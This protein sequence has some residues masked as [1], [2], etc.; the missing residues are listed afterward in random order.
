[1]NPVI[2]FLSD[3][4]FRTILLG[5][6]VLGSVSGILGT[7]AVLRRQGLVGDA[8]AH[9]ALPGVAGAF[10]LTG[11][12]S[13][14]VLMLGAAISGAIGLLI[15]HFV[16]RMSKTG[17]GTMLGVVLTSMFGF[18]VVLLTVIQKSADGS[19]AGIDKFLFGQAAAMVSEQVTLMAILGGLAVGTLLALLKEIKVATFDPTFAESIGIPTGKL[20]L[21]VTA[22]I[23]VAIVIGLNSVGVILMSAMLVAPAAAAR[24]WTDRLAAMVGISAL[25]GVLAGAGGVIVSV[26]QDDLPTGPMI[27]I[28]LSAIVLVSLLFG[29]AG[30]IVTRRLRIARGTK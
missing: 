22:L 29:S 18:G 16:V 25:F 15:G 6:V 24:Q 3:Y 10:L 4:T 23:L 14:G 1:M 11:T 20:S 2:E 13:N 19:Q 28:F 27:V 30:G 7:F 21:L 17:V 9:A 8:L 5:S 26:L 12:R